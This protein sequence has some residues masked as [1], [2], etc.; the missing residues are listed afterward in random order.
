MTLDEFKK[1]DLRVGIVRSAERV[2]QSAK[3]LGLTVDIGET[4]PRMVV[5]GIG[6]MYKPDE[7]VGT[8]IVVVANMEPRELAG[9]MSQGMLLAAHDAEGNPVLLTAADAAAAGSPIS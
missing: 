4:E 5:A 2:P 3:L 6:K 8:R 9:K 7:L 1:I